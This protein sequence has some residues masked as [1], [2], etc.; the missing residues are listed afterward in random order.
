MITFRC[1]FP[2]LLLSLFLLNSADAR[3]V[4][5]DIPARIPM[6]HWSCRE[7]T[8]LATKYGA[9][10]MVPERATLEKKELAA[11]LLAVMEKVLAKCELEGKEAV[12]AE[13]LERIAALHEALKEELAQ[14]EGYRTRRES[15]EKMLAKPEIPPFEYKVG[16]NGT[17]RGE[18]G[19]NFRLADLSYA[20]GH[21][22]GRFVYRVKP[23]AYW[24]PTEWLDIHAEG[25]EYG[26]TGS[27]H[28]EYN[29]FSLY[30][31]FIEARL[32]GSGLLALK[33]GRQEFSYGSAFII[34]PD[35]F[36]DGLP[37]DAAR[38]RIRPVGPLNVD[39]LVGA[40]A[41]PFSEGVKG[42][43][44]GVYTT[45]AIS[46]GNAVEA[47]VFRDTG[48]TE[49]RPGEYLAI[50]GVR[51][52]AKNGP[53]SVEVEP[54]FESGRIFND[55]RGENERIEAFG[56]HVDLTLESVLAGFNNK[57]F[58]SYAFG[59]G[60]ANSAN[61]AGSAREFKNPNRDT[62]LV[63]DM[64]L[65]RD[66]SGVTVDG[67]HASGLRIYTLG[68]GVDLTGKLNFSATGRYFVANAVESGFRNQLGLESDFT[69]TWNVS[70]GLSA[71]AGYDRFF[72]DGFFR[73][74]SGSSHGI[75]YGYLMLQFD[76]S[77]SKPRP[78]LPKQARPSP[79]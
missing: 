61:G 70:E 13:D 35:S 27:N 7:I 6:D 21:G 20:P 68:L 24:H 50:W 22:E 23:Y 28:Q 15:I 10:N 58:A 44:A 1:I 64:G 11:P 76:L 47:Y 30:Q 36:F 9:I 31:G 38:L 32:P 52:T 42:N 3:E 77:K 60:S 51:G 16:I 72:T 53:L 59:S 63:G 34:G 74:A 56:G 18:G 78:K 17:L 26:L 66:M 4:R 55:S 71:I 14:Y 37:F 39:L 75:D 8:A 29:K 12:P 25:Q 62:S 43:L 54:D 5:G 46:E 33:V 19:G 49:R 48:P 73:D 69:L 2:A 41:T 65:I 57:L 79:G 40:Y 67:H 45:Y